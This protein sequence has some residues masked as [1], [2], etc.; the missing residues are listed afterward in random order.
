MISSILFL[1]KLYPFEQKKIITMINIAKINSNKKKP[2]FDIIFSV[3][4]NTL[5]DATAKFVDFLLFDI[6][7]SHIIFLY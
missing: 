2:V 4:S 1:S 7:N 5:Q 6:Q 3:E